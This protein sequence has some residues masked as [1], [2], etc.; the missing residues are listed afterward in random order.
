MTSLIYSTGAVSVSNGSAVVT[1][2]LTGWAVALVKGG[3]FSCAGFAIPIASV[4]DDTHLTLAYPWPG[5]DATAVAYAISRDSSEAVQAAWTNDR[6]A[7]IIQRLS[8]VGVHADGSGTI[9]ERDALSPV[10]AAGFLWLR[11]EPDEPLEFYRKVGSGWEGPFPV[12]GDAGEP[13]PIGAGLHPAGAW[14]IGDTY[15]KGDYVSFGTRTFAS[16]ADGNVGNEPPSADVDDAFWMWTPAAVGP[17]GDTGDIGPEGPEGPQGEQGPPGRDGTG[18]GDVVGPAGVTADRVA[19]FDGT[20]GKLVKDGGKTIAEIAPIANQAAAEAGVDNDT[21]M[22]PLRTAQAIAALTTPF[23]PTDLETTVS[24]L[25]IQ[26][27]DATNVAQFLGPTG[28]RFADSFGALTFVEVAGGTNLDTSIAGVLKPFFSNGADQ[29]ATHTGATSG[30]NVVSASSLFSGFP[31]WQAFDKI[32]GQAS[33]TGNWVANAPTG[34]LQYQ[35]ASAKTVGF[36]TVRSGNGSPT[37]APKDWTLQG[38]ATGSFTGEQA[39]LDTRSNE[40]AWSSSGQMRTFTISSPASFLYYR[41]V[42]T[43][44]NGEASY[45]QIDEVTLNSPL[46]NGNLTVRSTSFAAAAAPSK[47]KGLLRVKK[48]DVATA[49]TDYTLECSRDGGTT[50]AAMTLAEMYTAAGLLYVEAAETS[51]AAQPSGTAP[52]WRFKTLNNKNVELHDLYLYWT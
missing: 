34:W 12:T 13:G 26:A 32:I 29:T 1:G 43:A 37:R 40:T 46:V 16:L 4:E 48:V 27:A 33:A 7:T 44:N 50:W 5:A 23:N 14:V 3:V 11:A 24:Q 47:M 6:L 39:T 22:T 36:Y 21:Y 30:G 8:L 19:V 9:A 42:V 51:V 10:P 35:F 41:L 25:A 28:N 18:Q 45:L 31:S 17:K 20:T 15:N 2:S 49:G 38:S 52:R